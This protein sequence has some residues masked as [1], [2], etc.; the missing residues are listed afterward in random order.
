MAAP[1]ERDEADSHYRAVSAEPEPRATGAAGAGAAGS[2]AN[3]R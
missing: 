1:A 3:A 2:A